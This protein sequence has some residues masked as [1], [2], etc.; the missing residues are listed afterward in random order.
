MAEDEQYV[1]DIAR[2][3][4]TK[5]ERALINRMLPILWFDV[6]YDLS[7]WRTT[8]GLDSLVLRH[9]YHKPVKA[10]TEYPTLTIWKLSSLS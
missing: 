5:T 8:Y 9:Q 7:R 3:I 10:H 2:E 6:Q 4:Q 1:R